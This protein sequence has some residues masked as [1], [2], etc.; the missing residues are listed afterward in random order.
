MQ[1]YKI[2]RIT[3]ALSL[4]LLVTTI[5]LSDEHTLKLQNSKDLSL[6]ES[7]ILTKLDQ[8]KRWA[9]LVGIEN[10]EDSGI[11]DLKYSV[12]DVKAVYKALVDPNKGGFA[13][14]N[15]RL[16]IDDASSVNL[17]PT[18]TLKPTRLNILDSLQNWL[19]DTQPDDTVLFYFSGHG[20][21]DKGGKNYLVP[22]DAKLGL[23]QD[24]A[25]SMQRVNEI[26]NDKE[27]IPA[28]KIVVVLDSCHSGT[29]V[30]A[31]AMET[32]RILD[33]LFTNAE[34]RVTL[35]SCSW[36]FSES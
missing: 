25:I 5:L 3:I 36:L 9:I 11:N 24:S 2:T 4:N 21:A 1:M 35:A 22:I 10:Y 17:H 12:D 32:G 6:Q 20:V 28:Q 34:G 19:R 13:P 27:L 23:L 26:L 18:E 33:P 29:R 8:N 14:Q 16:L 7:V 31:K 15:V 30:D